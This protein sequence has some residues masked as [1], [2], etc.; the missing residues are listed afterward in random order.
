MF[1]ESNKQFYFA[2]VEHIIDGFKNAGTVNQ[3]YYYMA[4]N[5]SSNSNNDENKKIKLNDINDYNYIIFFN[6]YLDLQGHFH[7]LLR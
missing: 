6:D 4:Q 1:F 5:L 2:N 7:L 3:E